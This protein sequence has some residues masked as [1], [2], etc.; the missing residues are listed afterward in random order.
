MSRCNIS[1]DELKNK[2]VTSLRGDKINELFFICSDGSEYLLNH[3]QDCCENVEI[4]EIIGDLNDLIDSP[5]L[6][7]ESYTN[8]KKLSPDDIYGEGLWTFYKFATM[9]GY[10]TIRW[11]GEYGYYGSEV[12]FDCIKEADNGQN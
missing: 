7:S 3:H 10:V 1:L 5:I 2:T 11:Y 4:E 6:M 12:Q 8:E 9:K